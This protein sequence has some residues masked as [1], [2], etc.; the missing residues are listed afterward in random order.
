MDP[1][2]ADSLAYQQRKNAFEDRLDEASGGQMR[3]YFST[4]V[5]LTMFIMNMAML[6]K[7]GFT[8]M[9]FKVSKAH[10]YTQLAFCGVFGAFVGHAMVAGVMQDT[11]QVE[12]MLNN[13]SAILNGQM[14]MNWAT[15]NENEWLCGNKHMKQRIYVLIIFLKPQ[16]EI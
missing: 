15:E 2:A 7:K 5:G 13:K 16:E 3:T 14:P 6:R 11:Q 12:Y 4:Q 1:S 10:L 9:P 8:M